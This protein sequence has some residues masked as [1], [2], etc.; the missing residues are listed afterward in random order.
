MDW[1][2]ERF[3]PG[4]KIC[5]KRGPPVFRKKVIAQRYVQIVIIN[6]GFLVNPIGQWGKIMVTL[7]ELSLH[8]VQKY[9]LV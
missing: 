3:F 5:T 7:I 9:F 6:G 8:T 2:L 1:T 4:P